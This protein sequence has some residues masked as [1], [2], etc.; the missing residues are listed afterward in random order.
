[1]LATAN[2][3]D[4]KEYVAYCFAMRTDAEFV[5]MHFGGEFIDPNNLGQWSVVNGGRQVS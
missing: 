3:G 1:V 2:I 5:Q 4:R